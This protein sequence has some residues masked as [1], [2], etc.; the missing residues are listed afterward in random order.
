MLLHMIQANNPINFLL[1]NFTDDKSLFGLH[2]MDCLGAISHNIQDWLAVYVA[3]VAGL[4]C[5]GK[6]YTIKISS[7]FNLRI[8]ICTNLATTFGKEYSI[9]QND[10][11]AI[12]GTIFAAL[13]WRKLRLFAR[14][15][16]RGE[17]RR[18]IY[19]M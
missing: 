17:L 8:H 9:F 16:Q 15:D 19:N 7:D 1:G 14:N 3:P 18:G 2:E 11:V 13:L 6:L 10:V 5:G 12:D 4:I